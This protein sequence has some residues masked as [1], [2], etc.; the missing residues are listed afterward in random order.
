MNGCAWKYSESSVTPGQFLKDEILN[1][2][3]PGNLGLFKQ[4]I[5]IFCLYI[6][7]GYQGAKAQIVHDQCAIP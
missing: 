4:N 6:Q 7:Q 3:Y 1:L 5:Y 2:V